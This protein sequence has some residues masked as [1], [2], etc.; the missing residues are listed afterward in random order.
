MSEDLIFTALNVTEQAA[1][2]CYDWVGRGQEKAADNAAVESMRKTLGA[3]NISGRIVIGEGERDEAP[4][5]FIGE[6]LGLGGVAMDIAVDPLEGTTLCA[7]ALSN[8]I[9][10]MA[11]TE[12]GK[13]LHAPDVYME[14]IAI[15]GG[16]PEGIIDIDNS[17][18]TNIANLAKAKKVDVKDIGVMI[19]ERPRHEELIAKARETGAR[20]HLI[21]DGDI[22][23]VIATTDPVKTGIDI[24]MGSGGAPEGVLASA[25]LGTI[26]GQMMGKLLFKNDEQ[27]IR[28]K[29]M[30]V[31]DINKKYHHYEMASGNIIFAATGVTSGN[32]L[33]GVKIDGNIITTQ[34]MIL[35]SKLK[36]RLVITSNHYK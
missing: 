31:I 30:G 8:S 32:M 25:A 35:S 15:G 27:I 13:L 5:L 26:G 16:Y 34:S 17:V 23:A 14:K 36:K 21:T 18:M 19:L 20:V 10:V 28:A 4:M 1:I 3:M 7:K 11:M 9:A 22:A 12:K 2:A 33:D 24:Y 6:E 29:S